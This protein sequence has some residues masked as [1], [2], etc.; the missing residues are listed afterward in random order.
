M[1]DELIK[2]IDSHVE[3]GDC[4]CG[5]CIDASVNPKQPNGHTADL[6]FFKVKTK[7]NPDK[8]VLKKLISEHAGSFNSCDLLD[9]KEHSYIEIGGWIGDQGE[10][11]MLMG[12]GE[13]V[14]L[15]KLLTPNLFGELPRDLVMQMAESGLVT[16]QV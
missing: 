10:A 4:Q 1:N 9:G 15:W 8:E 11:L 7:S 2:Y 3:R 16:I 13:L 5:K 12:L 6:V 14:G